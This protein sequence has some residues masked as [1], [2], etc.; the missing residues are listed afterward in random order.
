MEIH[1]IE[2]TDVKHRYGANIHKYFLNWKDSKTDQNFFYWLDYG[3]G[4]ELS[5]EDCKREKLE[6]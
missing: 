4:K 5:L 6:K 3:E 2:A 1:W